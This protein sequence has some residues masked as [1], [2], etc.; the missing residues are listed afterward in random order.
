MVV[1]NHILSIE[2]ADSKLT[3]DRAI[4]QSALRSLESNMASFDQSRKKK[5]M[6]R[7]QLSPL[8]YTFSSLI[9][10]K[11]LTYDKKQINPDYALLLN[12]VAFN[13][14]PEWPPASSHK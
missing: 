8:I 2:E 10:H 13:L 4:D 11:P 5:N 1:G 7:S 9:F 14:A 12:H 3:I 6:K